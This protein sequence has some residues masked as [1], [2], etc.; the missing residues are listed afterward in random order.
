MRPMPPGVDSP[1]AWELAVT[2]SRL[3]GLRRAVRQDARL[4]E[5]DQRL[6][7]LLSSRGPSTLRD[8][9]EAL[10]LEQSTVNRQVNAALREGL[11]TRDREPGR[12]AWTFT[13]TDE[14]LSLFQHDLE[15]ALGAYE[16]GLAGLSERDRAT[17]VRLLGRFVSQYEEA[18]QE[19]SGAAPR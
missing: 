1:D 13:V 8:I 3:D 4:G 18:L 10:G 6:M 11:L 9:A 19:R 14:G 12:T 15:L 5:A 16:A 2:V 17:L 7:W